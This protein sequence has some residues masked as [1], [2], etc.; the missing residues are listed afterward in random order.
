LPIISAGREL[1]PQAEANVLARCGTRP[2]LVAL[3]E[4]GL[5]ALSVGFSLLDSDLPLRVG[6]PVFLGNAV[7][8]LTAPSARQRA[9]VVRPGTLLR[10]AAAGDATTALLSAP[11]V[12]WRR[13]ELREGQVTVGHGRRNGS[14]G[15]VPAA[16]G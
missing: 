5:R 1:V 2:V 15:S 14:C 4:A 10:F 11:G 8:W 7:N 3:D 9:R 6:F 12:R 16:D 13:L